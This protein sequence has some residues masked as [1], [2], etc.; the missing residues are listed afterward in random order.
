MPILL[1]DPKTV[2]AENTPERVFDAHWYSQWIFNL[3][4]PLKPDDWNITVRAKYLESTTGAISEEIDG[5]ILPG[6]VSDQLARL[7]REVPEAKVAFDAVLA[8]VLPIEAQLAKWAA[9]VAE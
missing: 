9:A 3:P 5:E 8:A 1:K 7:I 2:P 6:I 4:D